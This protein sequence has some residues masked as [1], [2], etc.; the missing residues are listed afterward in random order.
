MTGIVFLIEQSAK[1]LY[2]FCAGI[3]LLFPLRGLMNS[4][5]KLRAA[6]FELEREE[7]LREQA[8]VVL[9]R[10]GPNQV[11]A[12]YEPTLKAK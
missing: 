4:R 7:A 3:L 11:A 6:E 1:G 2:L 9:L 5:R 8:G 12:S 10:T